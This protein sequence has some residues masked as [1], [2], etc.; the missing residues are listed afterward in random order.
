MSNENISSHTSRSAVWK[1]I[2]PSL[3]GIG[4]FMTPLPTEE[5]FTIPVALLSNALEGMLIE[6]LPAIMTVIIILSFL[7][8]LIHRVSR[9]QLIEGTPFFKN[10]FD[11]SMFWLIVRLAAVIFAIMTLFQVGPE[12]VYSEYTGGLLLYD[13]L[14]LLFTIFLFAGLFLPLLLNFGLLEFFGTLLAKLMRPLF[15]L[16]GRSSI[17]S[18]TSW[19]GDGTI[20]VILTNKQYE[21]GFYSKREAAVIGTTFSVVSITFSL[22]VIDQVGLVHMFLPFYGT[23]IFTGIIAALIMPRIPPLSRKPQEYAGGQK[24]Q[25]SEE[26]PDTYSKKSFGAVKFGFDKAKERADKNTSAGKFFK[27]GGK[28]VLDMWLGVAPVVMAFGTAA[29]ILAE[30]TPV[31]TWLGMPF[32]PILELMQVPEAAAA[33]E[34]IIVGFADMFL[35]A[36]FAAGIESE[37]TRFIIACLSVSQLIF[38]SEVGGVLLGSK[39]PVGFKDLFI[40]FL[41]RTIIAL[42]IIVLI[43]HMI[44]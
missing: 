5:G 34:T 40:I 15:T 23:V 37:M 44:F 22:V 24:N 1:F 19:L 3:I 27:D 14:P 25:L 31:F 38:L 35:P 8:S 21:E 16:P 41:E 11:V 33:S 10:L 18:L 43:A 4:L 28:N 12:A 39:I 17:D 32:V 7:G 36:I 13:L 2:I 30:Y 29:V 42:P 20:G 9:P 26:L 6:V